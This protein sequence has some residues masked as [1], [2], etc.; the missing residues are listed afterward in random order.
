MV[1]TYRVPPLTYRMMMRKALLPYVGLP[2]ILAGEF[3]VPELIQDEATPENLAQAIGNWLDAKAPRDRLRERFQRLHE[4]LACDHDARVADALQTF[5]D[6]G[7]GHG[8]SQGRER[9]AAMRG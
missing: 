1:I 8:D 5:L 4:Q 6:G 7:L 2:N 9:A 3:V